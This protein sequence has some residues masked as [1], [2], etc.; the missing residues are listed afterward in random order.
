M[1]A[2]S[3]QLVVL[4]QRRALTHIHAHDM[5]APVVR[6]A[7]EAVQTLEHAHALDP[8]MVLVVR[9]P[10]L[11]GDVPLQPRR[12]PHLDRLVICRQEVVGGILSSAPFDLVDLLLYLQR[13]E[14][15]KLR[16][17]GL[18]LG[19]EFILAGFFLALRQ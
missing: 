9:M 18:E 2:H 17:V 15:V 3:M 8:S 13:L 11:A 5:Q 19:V 4:R 14:V 1:F 7:R 10:R 16:L 12:V 6:R